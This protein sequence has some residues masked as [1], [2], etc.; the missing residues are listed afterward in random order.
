MANEFD[1]EALRKRLDVIIQ[2]L[3]EDSPRYADTIT[4]KI[5]SLKELGLSNVETA[6]VINKKPNY[7]AAVVSDKKRSGRKKKGSA[8]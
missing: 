1:G 3:L 7:V 5:E 8:S 6:Q 2:L 4:K